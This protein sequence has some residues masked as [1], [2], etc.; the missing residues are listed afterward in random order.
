MQ[1]LEIHISIAGPEKTDVLFMTQIILRT[2]ELKEGMQGIADKRAS[3]GKVVFELA[4]GPVSARTIRRS[5]FKSPILN[6]R[7]GIFLFHNLRFLRQ[8]PI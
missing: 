2:A 3:G 8:L 6:S 1:E 7:I 4:T 5:G